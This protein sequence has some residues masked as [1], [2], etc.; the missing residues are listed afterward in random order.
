MF[1][2]ENLLNIFV[3]KNVIINA[4][5]N[6]NLVNIFPLL[7]IKTWCCVNPGKI[8]YESWVEDTINKNS[9]FICYK[10]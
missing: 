8:R 5:I 10:L 6:L 9:I 1:P 3:V 2:I 4:T 7:D